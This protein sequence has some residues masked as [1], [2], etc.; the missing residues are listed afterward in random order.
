M[1]ARILGSTWA[2]V[3]GLTLG[4][5]LLYLIR[6]K[7]I[8]RARREMEG[9]SARVP[10]PSQ[11]AKEHAAAPPPAGPREATPGF[12]DLR[13]GDAPLPDMTLVHDGGDEQLFTRPTDELL[14]DS[15]PLTSIL[16]SFHRNRLQ[17]VMVE[18]P[19]G[20]GERVFNGRCAAWGTPKQISPAR[21]FWAFFTGGMDAT[22]AVYERTP[23]TAKAALIITSKYIQETREREK[24][25]AAKG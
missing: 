16:Y 1:I 4:P 5:L 12:R 20:S 19:L 7:S 18:M 8:E 6:K 10:Q 9:D 17:A 24:A 3:L 2:L 14:F 11:K 15:A 13:W 21:Y 22:Q 25:A 23:A